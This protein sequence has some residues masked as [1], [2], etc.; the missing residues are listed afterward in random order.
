MKITI[1][2]QNKIDKRAKANT[3]GSAIKNKMAELRWNNIFN[4]LE[5]YTQKK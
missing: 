4:R 2:K 3:V 5:N 1:I